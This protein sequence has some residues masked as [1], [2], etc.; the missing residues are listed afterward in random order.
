MPVPDEPVVRANIQVA[1]V[2]AAAWAAAEG[3]CRNNGIAITSGR[4]REGDNLRAHA[5]PCRAISTRPSGR[6]P[7]TSARTAAEGVCCNN[8]IAVTL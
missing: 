5:V 6:R 8:G 2:I 7:Q 3:V 1:V 4:C